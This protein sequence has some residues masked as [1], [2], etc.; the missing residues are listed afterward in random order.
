MAVSTI[1]LSG[2]VR[3]LPD[4]SAPD[5]AMQELINLRP[6]D[7]A[8]RPVGPKE[9]LAIAPRDVRF[10]HSINSSLKVY[11]GVI[12]GKIN[13]WVYNNS[14]LTSG[15]VATTIDA[16]SDMTFANL[17]NTLMI[18]NNTSE[19][20]TLLLFDAGTSAYTVF[21]DFIPDLPEVSLD[22]IGVI[23]ANDVHTPNPYDYEMTGQDGIKE[24]NYGEFLRMQNEKATLGYLCGIFLVRVA[25]ELTDG[26]IV[27]HSIPSKTY[28]STIEQATEIHP[29]SLTADVVTTFTAFNLTAYLNCTEAWLNEVKAKY[30]DIVR[31]LNIYITRAVTPDKF[32]IYDYRTQDFPPDLNTMEYYLLK[33]IKLADIPYGSAITIV[34]ENVLDLTTKPIMTVDNFTHHKIYGRRLFSYND[35]IFLGDIKNTLYPGTPTKGIVHHHGLVSFGAVYEVGIEFDITATNRTLTVFTGWEE[36]NYYSLDPGIPTVLHFALRYNETQ[37]MN[38]YFGY[39]DA[40]AKIARVYIRQGGVIKLAATKYLQSMQEL[41]FSYEAGFTVTGLF[42]SFPSGSLTSD[43]NSYYDYNRAQAT[44]LSNPFYFPAINSYR[45]GQGTILGFSTNA[46][47]LSSGQFGEFPLFCFC[48]DGIWAMNIGSG[49]VLINTIKPLAREVCNNPASITPIDGG[50]VFSTSK[51][52]FVITGPKPI[53]ISEAPEG[54]HL[55]RISGT[56]NYD[57]IANNPNLYQIKAFLCSASFLTYLSGAKI[58]YDYKNGGEIIVSNLSYAYS[59]VFSLTFKSWFKISEVFDNF[60]HDFPACYG[61]RTSGTDLFQVKYGAL[62]NWYAAT[63]VRGITASGWRVPTHNDFKTL[64]LY[65]DPLATEAVYGD[66]SYI[67]SSTAGAKLKETGLTHWIDPNTGATNE[68]GFNARGAGFRSSGAFANINED[69]YIWLSNTEEPP[70]VYLGCPGYHANTEAYAS[71]DV[72]EEGYSVRIVRESTTLTHGQSG[73]YIGNDG[74]AYRTICIGTQEWLADN[75]CE[76]KFRDGSLIPVVTDNAT[77]AALT[78]AGMC[79]YNN[80]SSNI[81]EESNTTSYTR[82]NLNEEDFSELISVHAETRPMKL[83]P[84]ALKKINRLLVTGF[85]NNNLEFPFSVNLFGST[86]NIQWYLL[87]NGTTFGSKTPLLIGRSTFSCKYYILVVGGKVDEEA[88]FQAIDVD[89]EE[90]YGNK[91]R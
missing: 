75:L 87:N 81:G 69:I 70:Y 43:A 58:G 5:G 39:P 61:F 67:E 23:S 71:S 89:Y 59:W 76:T 10:I 35:R 34:K 7:G 51:G 20:L 40:R 38:N 45:I 21:T 46:I 30:K 24:F 33:E 16:V 53:E 25:W 48:S 73:I 86:D 72:K 90:R 1:P 52:L 54:N 65:L 55:G 83:T 18:G 44:E 28:I 15:P 80:L 91:I 68:V 14:V 49:E 36:Y 79:A 12:T 8:F 19:V 63:D 66:W 41:N 32:N 27:R 56:L 11:I 31:S 85:I 77:W 13:Y 3:N 37:N 88:Y 78:S 2:I 42:S 84:R 64:I 74:K 60:V 22:K 57:A 82:F 50:T 17:H 4:N 29:L 26:T 9:S 6:R 47:A 62:Y